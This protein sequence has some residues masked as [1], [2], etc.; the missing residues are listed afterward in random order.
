VSQSY[1]K[2]SYWEREKRNQWGRRERRGEIWE[3]GMVS[4]HEAYGAPKIDFGAAFRQSPGAQWCV[5]RVHDGEV[6]IP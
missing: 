2:V 5:V 3:G 1:S 4:R 6:R